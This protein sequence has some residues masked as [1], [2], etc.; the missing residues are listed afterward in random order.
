MASKPSAW[1]CFFVIVAVLAVCVSSFYIVDETEQAVV[2]RF[3]RYLKTADP[4]LQYK[5]P[6]GIDKNYNVP[7]RVVQTEQFGFSTLKAGRNNEYRNNV[8]DESSMLTGDLNIVD[9]EWIIQYRI[10]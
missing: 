6:F 7:V 9:V 1:I 4:G 2:T 8:T 10:I 3:G 5:M